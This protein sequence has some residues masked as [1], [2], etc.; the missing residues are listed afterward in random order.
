MSSLC[1]YIHLNY[2]SS[3]SS[4]ADVSKQTAHAEKVDR[5][6]QQRT[7]PTLTLS[8]LLPTLSLSRECCVVLGGTAVD[9]SIPVSCA[10]VWQAESLLG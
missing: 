3:L 4:T 8:V 9:G 7:A 6:E 2:S 5:W 10:G 1:S